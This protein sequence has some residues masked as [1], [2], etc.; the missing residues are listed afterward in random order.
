MKWEELVKVLVANGW[1]AVRS[2]GHEI[3]CK[4]GHTNIVVPHKH[5]R[6]IKRFTAKAIIQAARGE[7]REAK[8]SGSR[9]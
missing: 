1:I 4:E 9:A 3:W 5:G 2:N 7:T 8:G 6:E